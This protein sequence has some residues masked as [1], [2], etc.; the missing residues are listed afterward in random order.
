MKYQI[1]V[2]WNREFHFVPYGIP[3]AT[4]RQARMFESELKRLDGVKSTRLL[5]TIT[6][7]HVP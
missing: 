1:E 5:D 7:K 4:I 2:K 3:F 6:G